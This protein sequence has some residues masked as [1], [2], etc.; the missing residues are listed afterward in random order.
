MSNYCEL[1]PDSPLCYGKFAK[2]FGFDF[3]PSRKG[4]KARY[5]H[6]GKYNW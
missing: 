4:K 6:R 1:N 3:N 2:R 5:R